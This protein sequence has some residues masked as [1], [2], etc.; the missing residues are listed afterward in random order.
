MNVKKLAFAA[1]AG[2]LLIAPLAMA[3]GK[4]KASDSA[5]QL[6]SNARLNPT[7][8]TVMHTDIDQDA[9]LATSG[10]NAS[11]LASNQINMN[12]ATLRDLD[13]DQ[14]SV[15]RNTVTYNTA[16]ATNTVETL[17]LRGRMMDIDQDARINA[18]SAANAGVNLNKVYIH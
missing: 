13:I 16:M 2:S 5:R 6:A 8:S 1:L 10:L 7:N 11:T 3:Q 12:D 14:D 17:G 15:A 4:G 9:I 18:L